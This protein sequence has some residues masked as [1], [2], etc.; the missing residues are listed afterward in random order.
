MR[1]E[2]RAQ[3]RG[4][5]DEG[6]RKREIELEREV[7]IQDRYKFDGRWSN[8]IEMG[9]KE[10]SALLEKFPEFPLRSFRAW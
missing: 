3:F 4:E 5:G 10:E 8:Q 1:L 6:V 9:W 2:R 7:H